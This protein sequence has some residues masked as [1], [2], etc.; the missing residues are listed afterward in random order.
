METFEEKLTGPSLDDLRKENNELRIKLQEAEDT[1][2]AIQSGSIDALA[3]NSPEGTRIYTLQGADHPYR[4]I[5]ETMSEGAVTL[6]R[7]LDVLYCNRHFADLVQLPMEK[8]MGQSILNYIH[9]DDIRI[10][11]NV[12]GELPESN[13]RE[14]RLKGSVKELKTLF[15]CAP[16]DIDDSLGCLIFT[17]LSEIKRIQEKLKNLNDHLDQLVLRRTRQLQ[18]KNEELKQEIARRIEAEAFLKENEEKFVQLANAIPQIAWM[19][20][21]Q[22]NFT[23]YNDRWYEFTG[24]TFEETKNWGWETLHDPEILPDLK[25]RWK[26]CLGTGEYFEMV[27]L[28]QGADGSYRDFLL[29]DIPV[30]NKE[31][32]I[33]QW[34]GTATDISEIKRI[35]RELQQSRERLN[36]ALENGK[37][38]IWE[39]N[40]KTNQVIWDERI[41]NMF[42][43]APGTFG[44]TFEDFENLVN[45]EDLP[46]V[47]K[48]I[49]Q[50]IENGTYLETI[51]R[52]RKFNGDGK[53]LSSKGLIVKDK[54]GNPSILMGV[55]FDVTEMKKDTEQMLMKL[56]EEL[57][58][59]NKELEQ[60][61]YV[62]SHDLQEPLRMVSS[63]TQLLAKKYKDQLDESAQ[64]YIHYAVDGAN[65]MYGLINGLLAYSRVHTRGKDFADVDMNSIILQVQTNLRMQISEKHA[66]IKNEELPV[67]VADEAQ[68][69]Q[70][71]QNLLNNALKFSSEIPEI[72]IAAKTD[73]AF[74]TFSV[75]DNGIGI[76]PQYYNR[77]FQI[78]QR[79]MPKDAYEGTGIGLSICKR[80]VERHEGKIWLESEPGKGS[81]FYFTIPKKESSN[82]NP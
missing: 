12:L 75:Q 19:A 62:A 16:I 44:G 40:L 82:G 7:Q 71:M 77:I 74:F 32:Q 58:R 10:F 67:I 28:I 17:D 23:W 1:I 33:I 57:L 36:M 46:H 14:I 35:E 64:E 5:I 9:P 6:S 69:I 61:A 15:S 55:V 22:G 18:K 2:S 53:Y 26:E 29:R 13:S 25:K 50:C 37:T 51:F 39:W 63:F 34:F 60:F 54:E 38:G 49:Q 48:A 78:F 80:I 20:D 3:V 41:E 56:N 79:L 76:E 27:S 81:V 59:S 68:M 45:E 8:I 4:V 31:G 73:Q 70:L 11:K 21:A 65:R 43:L 66:V 24:K 47:Q 52:T 72:R 30:K 42:H